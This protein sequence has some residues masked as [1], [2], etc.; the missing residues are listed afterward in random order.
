MYIC[1]TSSPS[2]RLSMGTEVASVTWQEQHLLVDKLWAPQNFSLDGRQR[3]SR[4]DSG[5]VS[6]TPGSVE[7]SL[8]GDC[9]AIFMEPHEKWEEPP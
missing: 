7:D 2:I 5:M 4:S 3:N 8:R 6:R 1:T 9:R